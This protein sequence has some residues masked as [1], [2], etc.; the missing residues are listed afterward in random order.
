MN[1]KYI[2]KYRTD[3][4][5]IFSNLYDLVKPYIFTYFKTNNITF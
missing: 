1:I 5:T 3:G 2:Y 4:R